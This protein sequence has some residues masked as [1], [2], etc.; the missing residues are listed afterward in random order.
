[1]CWLRQVAEFCKLLV[2][3]ALAVEGNS[4]T[5]FTFSAGIPATGWLYKKVSEKL[6]RVDYID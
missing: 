4:T 2:Q 6:H 5:H 3:K 1:M